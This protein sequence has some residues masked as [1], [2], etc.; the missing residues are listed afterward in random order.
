[1]P[2]TIVPRL[3]PIMFA[4]VSVRRRKNERGIERRSRAQL[5]DEEG[6]HQERPSR[7]EADGLGRLPPDVG[8]PV[9]ARRGA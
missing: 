4:P 3:K 1:M 7:E 6:G 8:G 9:S 5:D 2:K